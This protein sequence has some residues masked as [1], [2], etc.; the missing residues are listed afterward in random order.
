SLQ[1]S[2]RQQ[3]PISEEEVF[4]INEKKYDSLRQFVKDSLAQ[5]VHNVN[6]F[7]LLYSSREKTQL[8]SIITNFKNQ[9]GLK[10]TIITFDSSMTTRDS[11]YEVTRIIGIRNRMNI[12]IGI[13][14]PFRI[15]SVWN[16]SL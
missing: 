4:K 13:S 5:G 3:K 10:I 7:K 1:C 11:V 2:N 14:I 16:D 8:D 9:A 12:T 6:D 15:V